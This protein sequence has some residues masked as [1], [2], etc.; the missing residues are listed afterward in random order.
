MLAAE[1]NLMAQSSQADDY[2]QLTALNDVSQRILGIRTESELCDVAPRLLAES[3]DFRLAFLNLEDNG[4]L[5]LRG[6]HVLD[7]TAEQ[8]L[9]FI[10]GVRTENHAPPAAIRRCFD[11]GKTIISDS[12]GWPNPFGWPKAILL[13]P[14]RV[15]GRSA[16]VLIACIASGG[17]DL[18][19]H[20]VQR[21][22]T[23]ANMVS[24]ALANI[25]AYATLEQR[26]VERTKALHAAQAQLVQSEKMAAL[27]T[28]VAGVCHEL[29]TPVGAIVSANDT[30]AR[31]T[32][33]LVSLLGDTDDS[34]VAR[35]V[36]AVREAGATVATGSERVDRIVRR[37][38]TFA[39][40][41]E[42][43]RQSMEVHAA[44]EDVVAVSQ[45][46][47]GARVVRRDYG[48][49]PRL[50]C[51]ARLCNQLFHNILTNAIEATEDD[52]TITISTRVH[53][54]EL[55]IAFDDDG[56]GIAAPHL[57]RIFDPGFTTKGVGVGA[58]LGLAIGF[59]IAREHGGRLEVETRSGKG[60]RITVVLP[61]QA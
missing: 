57:E 31:A 54:G 60:T 52:G 48:D 38:R 33:K 4:K 6:F 45:H 19:N 1:D 3:L 21:F 23:F 42:S 14:I 29:N 44:L 9:R 13:T 56:E 47:L 32:D 59:E 27:G 2:R 24:L 49:V 61:L 16:G 46:A 53:G 17:R 10:H 30:L 40:L 25:R 5:M 18:A 51:N 55:H 26:V 43:D 58:G 41:D 36:A 15:D 28:L 12:E 34:R 7:S 20:D 50:E 22:E 37:L 39:R 8:R 35:C 11:S